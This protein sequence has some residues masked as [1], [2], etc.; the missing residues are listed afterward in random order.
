MSFTV[1]PAIIQEISAV[2]RESVAEDWIQEFQIGADTS[3][4][5]DLELESIEFV[6]IA[7]GL[8]RHF[9][10]RVDLIG[11]LATKAFDELIALRVGNVAEFVSTRLA[12]RGHG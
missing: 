8:Q 9:G 4:N 3:F 1:D 6:T 11:W 12:D 5:D 7:A 2:I 10:E